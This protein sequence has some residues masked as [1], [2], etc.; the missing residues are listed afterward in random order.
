MA[1]NHQI[2]PKFKT[3]NEEIVA[4]IRSVAGAAA[5]MDPKTVIRRKS[6]EIATAMALLHGGEWH[7]Q[8][9]HSVPVVLIRPV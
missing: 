3:R 8:V 1:I 6:A 9:D 5:P 4:R 2:R 7:A